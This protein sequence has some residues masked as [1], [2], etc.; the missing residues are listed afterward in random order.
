MKVYIAQ[1]NVYIFIVLCRFIYAFHFQHVVSSKETH[2][3]MVNQPKLWDT[4]IFKHS[5]LYFLHRNNKTPFAQA[6][7]RFIYKGVQPGQRYKYN[8]YVHVYHMVM[9]QQ[10][11][12]TISLHNLTRETDRPDK[13]RDSELWKHVPIWQVS[14]HNRMLGPILRSY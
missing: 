6:D 8:I 7:E 14:A 4:I 11:T 1:K 13:T 12:E 3:S 2:I 10:F 9:I 5:L